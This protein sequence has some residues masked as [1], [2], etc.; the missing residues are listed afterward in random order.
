MASVINESENTNLYARLNDDRFLNL[1][2]KVA[3]FERKI[4]NEDLKKLFHNCFFN[5][6][7]TT[8]FFEEDGSV[9][10][11]TGDIPA[12]W[13]RDSSAQVM[14][15]L[16][17]AKE[18]EEV[19]DYIKGVLKKQWQYIMI[20]PYANA[21]N[22]RANGNGHI[23]D[24]D[25]Q[26]PWVWERKFELDS[27]CYPLFLA[28]RY[29][30]TT[31]DVTC[32]DDA[33]FKAFDIICDVFKTEQ[34]HAEESPY[35]HEIV[36]SDHKNWTGKGKK[37]KNNG[38]VWSG[39]RP[40]D[41]CNIYGYYIPGNMFIVSVMTKLKNIFKT[42]LS[43]VEREPMCTYFIQTVGD[44]LEDNCTVEIEDFGKIYALETDGLG[45]YNIM[46]DANIP[47]LISMPYYEYPYVDKKIYENTRRYLVSERN[48]YYFK[49][50]VLTGVG[51][52]HTPKD[53]IWPLSLIIMAL[54]SD[55]KREINGLVK[56]LKNSTDGTYYLHEGIHKDDASK[57]TRPW[58]AW[59]NSLFSYMVLAKQNEIDDI[60]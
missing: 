7:D 29:F 9:F 16:F 26:S 1:R 22:R 10:I 44:A 13:L 52:P 3:L 51:S 43:D 56:M 2:K 58:F 60:E 4:K 49:G 41:D 21:F 55:D 30:E 36:D 45:N 57:Y 14:Q 34:T 8:S 15:Y 5:T 27:L 31:N 42:V 28:C 12:M 39:Y 23:Y 33:F 59:A 48:P 18:D 20:D 46:E 35:Y 6:I 47:N 40:S 24:L 19:R 32:F 37:V 53:Y 11:L 50:K 54:T 25:K 17:F 38:M